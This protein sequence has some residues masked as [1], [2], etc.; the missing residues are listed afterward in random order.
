MK[1]ETKQRVLSSVLLLI[2][3]TLLIWII[4]FKMSF[5][6]SDLTV[7]RYLNLVP[8]GE[9]LVVNGQTDYSEIIQNALI[10]LPFGLLLS[11]VLPRSSFLSKLFVIVLA[12]LSL[13]VLQYVLAVGRTDITDLIMN[14]AGGFAGLIVYDLLEL[15]FRSKSRLNKFLN[16]LGYVTAILFIGWMIYLFFLA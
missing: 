14:S 13:E 6:M 11:M 4:L 1:K 12:S 7:T 15:I 2:Y 10:F 8:F 16:G 5:S 9:P 3:V